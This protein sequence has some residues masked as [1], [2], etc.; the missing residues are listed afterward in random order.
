MALSKPIKYQIV[1]DT[2]DSNY[3]VE[4]NEL[5]F[6]GYNNHKLIDEQMVMLLMATKKWTI[7]EICVLYGTFKVYRPA[8]YRTNICSVMVQLCHMMHTGFICPG[9]TNNNNQ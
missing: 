8:C 5:I 1:M 7:T 6:H 4:M 9:D 2:F 3:A